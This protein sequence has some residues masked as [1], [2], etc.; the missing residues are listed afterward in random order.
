LGGD[1]SCAIGTWSGAASALQGPLGLIWVDAHLDSHTPESSPSKNIHGMPL[2]TLLGY[3]DPTLTGIQNAKPK[4][5]PENVVLIGIRHYEPAEHELLSTLGVK[6]FYMEDIT[7]MGLDAVMTSALAII[8]EKTEAF[9][10]SVDVDGIDPL[11][12]PGVGY[13]EPNGIPAFDLLKSLKLLIQNKAF[14][15]AEIAEFNPERDIEHKT[16]KL[17]IDLISLLC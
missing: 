3:G 11:D 12:A 10:I 9:G 7:E 14:I 16:E 8:T 15:G 2:A 6:I 4:I 5:L 13:R 17:I 1:H